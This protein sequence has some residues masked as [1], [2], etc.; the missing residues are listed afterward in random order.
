VTR[1]TATEKKDRPVFL[2]DGCPAVVAEI[3]RVADAKSAR[4]A[5]A[6]C[7]DCICALMR[8]AHLP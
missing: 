6:L 1:E 3:Y 2:C 4:R 8:E 5:V 7:A